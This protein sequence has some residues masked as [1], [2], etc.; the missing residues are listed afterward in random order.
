M[1]AK[2]TP[3]VADVTVIARAA[4]A[5]GADAVSLVNTFLGTALDWRRRR[6]VFRNV[7]AGLSGPAIKP[8]ALWLVYR[9]AKAVK[10]PVV[11]IG[12]I[13]TAADAME[14]LLAGA[15]AVQVGTASFVSPT[16]AARVVAELPGLLAEA[17][18]KSVAEYRGSLR[19][20]DA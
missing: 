8:M 2:L 9:T 14:F 13:S 11:G 19:V 1:I 12:G 4:E 6:P 16:A 10:I 3:N 15:S 18:A 17:G 20:G 5:A 7:V